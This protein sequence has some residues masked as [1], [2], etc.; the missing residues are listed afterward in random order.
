MTARREFL[1]GTAS[2]ASAAGALPV[3]AEGAR[4]APA[5]RAT[6][7][8]SLCGEW[9]F[10]TDPEDSGTRER[11]FAADAPRAAW[12]ALRVPHTWQVLPELT[13]YRGVAWYARGFDAPERWAGSAVRIEFEAVYHTATVWI[14]GRRVGEHA[15]K[16]Y[17]AFTLEISRFLRLGSPNALVVRVD[18]SFDEH[19]LPRGRSSDFP[20]DG[21]IFRPLRLLIT[22]EAFVEHVHVEARP[23]PA[24]GEA[25]L[26]IVARCRNTGARAWKGRASFRVVEEETGREVLS[27][28]DAGHLAIQ[29]G[30]VQTLAID[31]RLAGARLWHFDRPHL[32]RLEFLIAG[33]RAGTRAPEGHCFATTFG[34]RSFEARDGSFYLN[35][36]RVRLMGVERMAGS[37]PEL[38]M[39]EPES[40]ISHDHEDLKQLNCVFTRVHWPQDTRV[41]DYCDRH[42][43]LVQSEIPAWGWDTFKGMGE[44]PDA[45]ILAN[46]IE[47]MREM[48]ARDRNHPCIVMWGL[49]NEVGG[50]HPPAY[51][52]SKRLLAEVKALDP[53]RLCSYASNSLEKDPERD[54]AG[55]MDVIEMNEYVG[56]WSAGNLDSIRGY[57]DAVHAAFPDK[58]IVI[59]EYGSCPCVPA[60]PDHDSR[61]IETL[62]THD[63]VFRSREFVAGA[64]FFCYNDYRSQSGFSGT[65]ALRQNIHGVVDVF[66]RRKPSFEALREE[67]SPVLALSVERHGNSFRVRVRTRDDLPAHVLRGY[68]V[69]GIFYGAGEI[70]RGQRAGGL[71]GM[72]PGGEA[73]VELEF[74]VA[75]P[76]SRIRF[77]VLRPNGFSALSLDWQP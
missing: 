18:N 54:V 48:I 53:E 29:P 1:I 71:A 6:E 4:S 12:L 59:S 70:R 35:G 58:P 31:A 73:R 30:A 63:G 57:L 51:Q 74:A 47:Q 28:P 61:R 34:V 15:R 13:E 24:H 27:N 25:D 8:S 37:N 52:F 20:H 66:G 22:P 68:R 42:G 60:P 65:G 2:L 11:W 76:A 9:L 17:T 33:A 7:A 40:W 23:D 3:A 69:R 75:G 14:N 45:D 44:E 38:G 39:A 32:Y 67:C 49:C 43:I 16:G 5:P 77:D 10:R 50:Q 21:G 41:L 55:L 72:G 64:I 19:M 36:E 46:G 56:T 26:A 62:R